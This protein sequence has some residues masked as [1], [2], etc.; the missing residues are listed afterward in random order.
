[1]PLWFLKF[2]CMGSESIFRYIS[3]VRSVAASSLL[4]CWFDGSSS[5]VS[6]VLPL[7]VSE[8]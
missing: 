1:M 8:R 3:K 6:S 7:H 2:A 4:D 5:P